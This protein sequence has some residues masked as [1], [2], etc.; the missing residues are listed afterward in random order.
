[1]LIKPYIGV[2]DFKEET[3]DAVKNSVGTLASVLLTDEFSRSAVFS[4]IERKSLDQL[5]EEYK[6]NLSGLTDESTAPEIGKLQG[7]E[8]LLVGSVSGAGDGY[9]ITDRLVEVEIGQI[10]SGSS[11]K[12]ARK[13]IEKEAER[14]VASTFQ[15]SSGIILAPSGIQLFELSSNN[16]PCLTVSWE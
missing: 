11:L 2:T 13:E 12:V 4:V 14:F 10:A 8:L 7:I 5:I 1:M 15:S 16:I 3:E 9:I 6:L